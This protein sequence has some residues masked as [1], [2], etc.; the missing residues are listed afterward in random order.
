MSRYVPE[1]S[2]QRPVDLLEGVFGG[3]VDRDV[4]LGAGLHPFHLVGELGVGHQERGNSA[5]VKNF[6]EPE[7]DSE[8]FSKTKP[9]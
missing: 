5:L 1:V 6:H 8:I 9:I 7:N 4:K 3:G 2:M